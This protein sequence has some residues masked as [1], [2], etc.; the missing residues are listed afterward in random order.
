VAIALSALA[1]TLP[2]A[3]GIVVMGIFGFLMYKLWRL[4]EAY[5]SRRAE[6]KLSITQDST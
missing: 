3:A 2:I 4:F 1:I 6:T 5:K